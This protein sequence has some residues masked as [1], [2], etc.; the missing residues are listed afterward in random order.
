MDIADWIIL[1][2][3]VFSAWDGYR[4][5]LISQLV[6]LLGTV[7]AY[8]SAWKFHSALVPPLRKWLLSNVLK[9]VHSL[10]DVPV[11]NILSSGGSVHQLGTTIANVLAFSIVFYVSL[12]VIRYLGHLLNSVFHLPGL[13]F[14]NRMAGMVAGVVVAVLLIAVLINFA[15][16]IPVPELKTQISHSALSP[17]F[18]QP[19]VDLAKMT[20]LKA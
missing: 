20:G 19:I 4:T 12:L 17:M 10:K 11:V 1:A 18:K 5:G 6:R 2:V 13:S 15:A 16:Y 8:V 9:N 14:F 7:L 3:L